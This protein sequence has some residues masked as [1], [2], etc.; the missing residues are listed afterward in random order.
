MSTWQN[1]QAAFLRQA[2]S[3]WKAYQKTTELQWPYCDRL[4]YLQMATEKLSK[5]LLVAGDME[6]ENLTGSH[7]AF[8]NFMRAASKNRKLQKPLGLKKSPLRL[9]F[10]KLMPLAYEI[11]SLAPTLAKDGP[12]PEYPWEDPAGN[13]FA[14]TDY[15][16]PL[17]N[18]LQKTPQGIQLLR[19]IEIFIIRF[20]DLFM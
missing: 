18:R 20:E 16:F 2:R 12:N 9:H 8:V 13:I 3:D 6:L 10:Q 19:H 17:I 5:A 4:H 7:A 11:Q 14:P 1:W 15:S